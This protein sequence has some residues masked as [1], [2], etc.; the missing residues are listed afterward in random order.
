[1]S[2]PRPGGSLFI[3]EQNCKSF[4][5]S[6]SKGVNCVRVPQQM[7]Q[8]W[9]KLQNTPYWCIL[10]SPKL[11]RR[12]VCSI[13]PPSLCHWAGLSAKRVLHLSEGI[14]SFTVYFLP[15]VSAGPIPSIFSSTHSTVWPS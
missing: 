14:N 13:R 3:P 2:W 10:F 11:T 9:H 12:S 7:R 4:V 15:F 5:Y 6:V 8:D 1:M